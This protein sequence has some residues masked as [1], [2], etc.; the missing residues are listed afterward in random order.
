M[1]IRLTSPPPQRF[2]H[3]DLLLSDT[4][5]PRHSLS[6]GAPAG[7]VLLFSVIAWLL[8]VACCR[9]ALWNNP[10]SIFFNGD[11]AYE[12]RYTDTRMNEGRR[13]IAAASEG[14]LSFNRSSS[15][16]AAICAGSQYTQRHSTRR[17]TEASRDIYCLSWRFSGHH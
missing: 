1:P 10:H 12:Y 7:K 16:H 17:R 2:D 15:N 13:W 3:D 8:S 6:H 4:R 9:H 5:K 11:K 14:E